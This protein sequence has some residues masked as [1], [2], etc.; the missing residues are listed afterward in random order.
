MKLAV[1]APTFNE[2]ENVVPFV[3]TVHKAMGSLDY[4]VLIV[5]D[6]SPDLTWQRVDEIA[7]RNPRV[8]VLRRTSER[9][10][11]SSVIDGFLHTNAEF[12]A[13][14]DA[15]LQHDPAV[16][17]T[18]LRLLE[19][20]NDLVI[21]SRYVPDGK[22]QDWSRIRQFESWIATK[23]AKI[24]L[25]IEVSDPMSGFFMMRREDFLRIHE[26]LNVQGFKILLEIL[27]ALRPQRVI[28]TPY[29][30][31]ARLAGE[32]KLSAGIAGAY[33]LQLLRLGAQRSGVSIRF[34]KFGLVGAIGVVVNLLAMATIV[35]F[36][37]YAGWQA[38]VLASTVATVNNYALNNAWTFRDRAHAGSRSIMG[39][40]SYFCMSLIGI[41]V[42]GLSYSF[43]R[44]LSAKI[45]GP[46]FA[47][48]TPT[49]V[50]LSCQL[51]SI[52]VGTYLNFTLNRTVTWREPL[53]SP[54]A[55]APL[56]LVM[57]TKKP[58]QRQTIRQD[59]AAD[60]ALRRRQG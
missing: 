25:G 16:L 4:E 49:A 51:L 44:F 6:D 45:L 8:G 3:D 40:F 32:S 57:S 30:F 18:M 7:A 37:G 34:F 41:A 36:S 56:N 46:A 33:L 1:I 12:I 43:L 58:G 19:E 20:S 9:G 35:S 11:A 2:S 59:A 38:S 5:D 55:V 48:G 10:L 23:L 53:R 54:E 17:P 14:I 42:T 15:D 24:C 31:R 52:L 22:V 26:K 47:A 50:I 28:E 21:G 29:T 13:C 39:Y 27:V 60:L